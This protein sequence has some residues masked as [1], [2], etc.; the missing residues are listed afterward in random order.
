ML[1]RVFGAI[2]GL[3]MGGVSAAARSCTAVVSLIGPRAALVVVGMILPLLVLL[4]WSRLV[5]AR[6]G[7]APCPT[8]QLA[9]ID[10]VPMF[11]PLSLAAKEHLATALVPSPSRG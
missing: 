3:A 10:H 6:P 1:T 4:A 9:M 11:A 8:G 7:A 5:G 2:W